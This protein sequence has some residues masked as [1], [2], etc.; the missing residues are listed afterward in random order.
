M[1]EPAT[2]PS[3]PLGGIPPEYAALARRLR[4]AEDRLFPL[5]MIDADR[6]QRAV[7]L[8]G[9]LDRRLNEACESIEELSASTEQVRFWLGVVATEEGVSL[10]GLDADLVVD[11]AMSQRLRTLLVEQATQLRNRRLEAARQAG[12]AWAVLEEPGVA[13]W[14]GGFARW[15]EAHVA[16][17]T[18]MVRSVAAD[19]HTGATVYRL[20][21]VGSA[22]GRAGEPPGVRTEEFTDREAWLASVDD[23]RSVLESES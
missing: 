9:A 17:G 1:S 23:V 11:A 13:A 19:Q 16:T 20:E 12:Q 3:E 18:V 10:D 8:V 15:V 2:P 6:Y 14:T 21:V 7:R 22:A 4:A 5:A